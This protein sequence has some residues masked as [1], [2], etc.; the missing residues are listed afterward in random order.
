M[1]PLL[2]YTL[3]LF[4]NT[5]SAIAH[6]PRPVTELVAVGP[7]PAFVPGED[8]PKA[9]AP[10]RFAH[11]KANRETHIDD[12]VVAYLFT[13]AKRRTIGFVVGAEGL[14]VRA[15]RW[16]PLYEVEAA[17]QEKGRWILRKLHETRER[18]EKVS[19]ARIV[20]ADGVV[21]PYLGG[22][23]R[24]ALDPTHGFS[25]KGAQLG[26]T[27]PAQT[28]LVGLPKTASAEQIRDAVQAW[29]MQQAK[30]LFLSRMEHYAPLLNVRWTRLRLSNAGTRW[31]SASADG[32]I[33][34]NWRLIH[35][36]QPVIDYVVAHE[37]SHLRV[38][39]HSR[40]FWDTVAT[41]VPD[42]ADLRRLL[43]ADAVPKW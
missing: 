38:M 2:R 13:R 20:W 21:I 15:P 3:D 32:S 29:L 26:D 42:Y 1:L 22:D 4:E 39:D 24:I 40:S 8:L 28:L 18:F 14:S 23:L 5:A 12:A 11:P 31:G 34:L 9:I 16:T 30:T 19:S 37:L 35:F 33:R 7:R 41:V 43:K 27:A 25:G 36:R 6:V 17:L 10:V